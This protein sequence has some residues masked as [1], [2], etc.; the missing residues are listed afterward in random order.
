M[1][2]LASSPSSLNIQSMKAVAEIDGEALE[3][4]ARNLLSVAYKNV[5]GARRGS[6]RV[7]N[8]LEHQNDSDDKRKQL[9]KRY[10][11]QIEKELTD[12]CNEVIVCDFVSV[13]KSILV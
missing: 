5:V 9:S 10:R 11:L 13:A 7:V 6:W 12:I 3:T 2:D 8:S 1:A 4:D